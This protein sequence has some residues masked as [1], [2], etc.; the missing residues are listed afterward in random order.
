MG[1]RC[2]QKS[3]QNSKILGQNWDFHVTEFLGLIN[4]LLWSK[5]SFRWISVICRYF[6]SILSRFDSPW[7]PLNAYTIFRP[8]KF[9]VT[10]YQSVKNSPKN[11]QNILPTWTKMSFFAAA[12]NFAT[13]SLHIMRGTLRGYHGLHVRQIFSQKLLEM[14][15]ICSKEG[16]Q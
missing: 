5:F 7:C 10:I 1:S 13:F 14:M 12:L 4:R 3:G 8:N 2:F 6:F 11:P 15:E 9:E 16:S